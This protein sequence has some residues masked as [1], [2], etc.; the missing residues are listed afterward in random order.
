M[1][2]EQPGTF[3]ELFRRKLRLRLLRLGTRANEREAEA[4]R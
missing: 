4:Y 1:T 3:L 2:G